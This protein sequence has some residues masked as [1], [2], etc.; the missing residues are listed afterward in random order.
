MLSCLHY[1][2]ARATWTL[3]LAI[4]IYSIAVLLMTSSMIQR[5]VL[6]LSRLQA[7]WLD[8]NNPEQFGF[9]R[10]QVTPFNFTTPDNETLYAW[11]IMPL[12][13]YA[14]Y[15]SALC[16]KPTGFVDDITHSLPFR[17]LIDNPDSR[18]IINFHGNAGDV[19]QGW[20][21]DSYRA[22]T[23][24]TSNIHILTVDYRGFG[25]STG[26]PSEKGVIIDAITTIK[27]AIDVAKIPTSRIVILGHS[28]GTAVATAAVEH[29][30]QQGVDFAGTVLVAPF[31]NMENV[32]STYTIAG[33]IPVLSPLALHP[34]AQKWLLS[35]LTGQWASDERIASLVRLS[36]RLRL[37][38]IHSMNDCTIPWHHSNSL[39]AAAAN[40]TVEGGM[41]M[42][43]LLKM[44]A[45]STINI[46][47]G[48]T[49]IWK[50]ESDKII[51]QKVVEYGHHSR[52]LTYAPVVLAVR[53][54]FGIDVDETFP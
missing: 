8:L 12:G 40:A 44:K 23:D 52:I 41:E 25:L 3:V 21:T 4:S 20:R 22:L 39:F 53:G 38:I 37:F 27:W 7:W 42:D 47:N 19:G 24:S 13:L 2:V 10:N 26:V 11:H 16:Q 35:G 9:A 54:A 34:A 43:L 17:L 50:A 29:Y 32:F 18:L 6:F 31:S 45:R 49:S 14:R 30:A 51:T 33:L 48:F 28:L 46:G 15:K 5:E 1:I 36:K